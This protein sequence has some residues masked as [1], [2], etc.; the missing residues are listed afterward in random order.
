[1]IEGKKAATL[2]RAASLMV[3]RGGLAVAWRWFRGF[4]GQNKKL[5]PTLRD[6]VAGF[7]NRLRA[8]QILL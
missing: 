2:T 3:R 5:L 4:G 8:L 7:M 6:Y 1:M